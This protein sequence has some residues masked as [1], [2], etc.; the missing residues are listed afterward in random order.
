MGVWGD[1]KR[2]SS[3]WCPNAMRPKPGQA[4]P[5]DIDA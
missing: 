5:L 4:A 2:N 3:A 1:V